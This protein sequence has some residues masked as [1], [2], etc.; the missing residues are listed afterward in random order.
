MAAIT[1]ELAFQHPGSKQRAVSQVTWTDY[2]PVSQI[3]NTSTIEFVVYGTAKRYILLSK[4]RLYIVVEVLRPDGTAVTDT[5]NVSLVNLALSSVF[6]QVDLSLNQTLIT[7]SVGVNY[8]YKSMIDCLVSYSFGQ[9]DSQLQSEFYY[10][11]TSF[12]MDDTLLNSGHI[13]RRNLTQAGKVDMCGALHVDVC[14]QPKA[15]PEKVDV[16]LKLYQAGDAFRLMSENG[17][18]YQVRI[19]DAIFKVCTI[20]VTES[21]RQAQKAMLLKSPAHYPMWKSNIKT[22]SVPQGSYTFAIDDFFHGEVPA[23]LYVACVS[24]AAY[25]GDFSKNPYNFYH[26]YLDYL[27]LAVDGNSV[28]SIPFQPNYVDDPTQPG[29]TL[30]SGYIREFLSLFKSNYPQEAGNWIQRADFPG[31]YAIYVFDLKPGT[32]DKLF[33]VP[34]KGHT[35]LS[36]RFKQELSEP[37]T[38]IAYGVFPS[39]FKIDHSGTVLL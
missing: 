12:S 20:Q 18:E 23:R 10:K 3:N 15:I 2:R 7:S 27:E 36:A 14:Q 38:I 1:K 6:R 33:S 8:G 19:T 32:T 31:G 29:K 35:R 4:S 22:Y 16:N 37:I 30:Q 26:Y 11:D 24:S 21:V 9:K 28:P 5:D 25:S 34:E 13:Q 17:A 39:S